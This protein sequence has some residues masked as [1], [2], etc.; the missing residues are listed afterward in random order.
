MRKLILLLLAV[1]V[2][3]MVVVLFYNKKP[4]PNTMTEIENYNPRGTCLAV[5]E[6][7]CGYCP[8]EIVDNK[9]YVKNIN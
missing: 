9:C 6:P 4:N 5:N 2:F 7:E 8:G 1:A 3:L